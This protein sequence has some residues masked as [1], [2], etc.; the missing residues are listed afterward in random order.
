MMKSTEPISGRKKRPIG[1]PPKITELEKAEVYQALANYIN[2]EDDP[3]IPGFCSWDKTAIKYN[4]MRDNLNDWPKFSTLIKK[5]I[6]KQEAYLVK[7]AGKGLYN[8]A[9]AIFR[10]KQ[11]QHGYKDRI[12]SDIT[13]GGDKLGVGLSANQ[14]EQLIR[15]RQNRG[16]I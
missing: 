13:S 10:L 11:P 3:T 5:A 6:Q 16:N 1:R 4:I 14:A 12:D 7:F 9:I 15:A 8:P 2:Q